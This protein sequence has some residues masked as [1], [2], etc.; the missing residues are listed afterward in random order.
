MTVFLSPV[1]GAGAQFFDN[2]GAPLSGGLLYTYLAGS[3]TEE[4]TYTSTTGAT[5][6][7]NPIVLDSAGRVATGEIW[8]TAG[9]NYKFI[10][11]TASDELIATYDNIGGI[12]SSAFTQVEN[13]TGDGS[14][15]SF[16]LSGSVV[17]SNF[18]NVYISGVYQFKN[19][20]SIVDNTVVFSEAPPY[21]ALIEVQY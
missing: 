14:Q 6:H 16:V 20:Y 1:G 4:A 11:K 8:L 15:V 18:I 13:F 2:N 5:P 12:N 7:T 9:T 3:S 10:L 17:S 19:T 21:N